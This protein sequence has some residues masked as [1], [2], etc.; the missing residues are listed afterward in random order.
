VS[1]LHGVAAARVFGCF[2]LAYFTSFALRTISAIIAPELIRDFELSNA[3]LGSLS[4]AYFLGFAALQLPLG[5]WLDRFGSR[6]THATLLMIAAA[7]C[8]TFALA[9]SSTALW[10][11]RALMGV[12]V[13]GGLMAALKAFRFWF[14]PGR[15]QQLAAWMLL[16]GSTGA[17]TT[18]VPVRAALP[19]LGWRGVFWLAA[20]LLLIASLTLYA[21]LPRDEERSSRAQLSG[22]PLWTG[23]REVF[24]DRYFQRFVLV[25]MLSQSGFISLQSLWAGPWLIQV[26][27]MTPGQAAQLLFAFNLVLMVGYLSVGAVIPRFNRH[28]G[29]MVRI[30]LVGTSVLVAI[31]FAIGAIQSESAWPLWLLLALAGTYFSTVQ[32]HVSLSF[33]AA[34]T[35][36]A[37]TAYNLLTFISIFATQWLFGVAIDTFRAFGLA[38]PMAFRATLLVTVAVQVAGLTVFY[39]SKARPRQDTSAAAP[40][41]V[42]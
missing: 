7:G 16:V 25:S 41:P 19:V 2:A 30:V 12:G 26:L 4:S 13:A 38:T 31:E 11:G 28:E 8:A 22:E 6:R 1:P 18:T 32:T 37:F 17:L 42:D 34:L 35:G 9:Q 33:P 3:Q 24:A 23:Y 27:G 36:R 29:S 21:V 5:I 14:A 10:C 15:Q 40:S 39:L 20:S